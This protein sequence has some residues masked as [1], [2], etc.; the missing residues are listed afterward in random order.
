MVEIIKRNISVF[1]F[2]AVIIFVLV[3]LLFINTYNSN[4]VQQDGW[5]FI[6]KCIFILFFFILIVFDYIFKYFIK[7]KFYLNFF[8][9]VILVLIFIFFY[10]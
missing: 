2:L 6:S 4:N 3:L 9:L 8:E 7:N 5:V 10:T 1:N